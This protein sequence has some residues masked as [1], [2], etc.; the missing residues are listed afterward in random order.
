LNQKLVVKNVAFNWAIFLTF[1]F[2][3]LE[4]IVPAGRSIPV[5]VL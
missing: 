2:D 5:F 3:S 4:L 1:N